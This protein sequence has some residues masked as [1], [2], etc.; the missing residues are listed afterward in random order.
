MSHNPDYLISYDISNTKRLQ[1]LARRLEKLA[2]R[3]QYSVFFAQ[4]I[5]QEDLFEIMETINDVIDDNEDDVRIYTIIDVGDALG[6][7]VD[8]ENPLLFI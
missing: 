7:A 8:L 3:I 2:I 5:G 4:A 1:K 6:R